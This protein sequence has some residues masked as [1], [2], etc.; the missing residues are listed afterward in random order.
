M[1]TQNQTQQFVELEELTPLSLDEQDTIVGG[2]L[3]FIP[4]TIAVVR[5]AAVIAARRAATTA[6]INA[7]RAT[8]TVVTA[9]TAAHNSVSSTA[10][11]IGL[12]I[13]RLRD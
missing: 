1:Q 10:P 11:S 7:V 4:L 8:P 9:T 3:P 2:L 5:M 6:T 12:T 13:E